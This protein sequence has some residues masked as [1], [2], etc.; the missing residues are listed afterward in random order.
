MSFINWGSESPEQLAIRR[1]LEQEAIYEQAARMARAR[2]RAGNAVAGSGGD[3]LSGL[4]GLTINGAIYGLGRGEVEWN[5]NYASF[6][7]VT[8]FAVNTDD[9]FL[10]AAVD[11]EGIVYFIKIDRKTKEF[12]FID[13]NISD[14]TTKGASSLYYEGNGSFIYLDN[15]FKGQISSILRITLNPLSP[16]TAIVHELSEVDSNMTGYLLRNLFLYDGTPWAIAIA[17]ENIITGP[18]D[19]VSGTFNY[20]NL[21]LP[22]PNEPN[23][24]SLAYVFSTINHNGAVYVD[25]VWYDGTDFQIGLFKMDTENGG[26][27][28]PYYLKFVKDLIIEKDGNAPVIALASF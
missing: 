7:D 2:Q 13:N 21:V 3:P 15:F 17:G 24:V 26:S 9:G 12:T 22:S 10:Y 5:Y 23:V 16:G 1:R 25:A 28:A 11:F 20:T 18:F 27:L 4:Y 19:I 6:P 14:F 8:A